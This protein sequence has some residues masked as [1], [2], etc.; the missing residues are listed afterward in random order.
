MCLGY[1][2]LCILCENHQANQLYTSKHIANFVND[3]RK[4]LGA[5]ELITEIYK[6]NKILVTKTP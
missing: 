5:E 2:I 4:D 6:G 1:K 3:I